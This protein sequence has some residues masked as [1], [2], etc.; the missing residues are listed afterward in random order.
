[1]TF[2]PRS[3]V[4]VGDHLRSLG[5]LDAG[6]TVRMTRAGVIVDSAPET[7]DR[8]VL[9]GLLRLFGPPAVEHRSTLGAD[10]SDLLVTAGLADA[11]GDQLRARC[12]LAIWDGLVIAHDPDSPEDVQP[13]TVLGVNNTTRTLARLT[14]RAPIGRALDVGCGG[15]ALAL[16]LARHSRSVVATDLSERAVAY[17]DLNAA[18]NGLTVDGRQGDLY[19]PARDGA[20]YDLVTANLPFVVSPETSYTFR[21]GGRGADGISQDAVAG[22]ASL[23][24]P[25]GLA[26]LLVNWIVGEGMGP[27]DRVAGW[28]EG[29]EVSAIVIHHSTEEP[30]AYARRWNEFLLTSDVAAYRATVDRWISAFERWEV[31]GIASGAVIVRRDRTSGGWR[32]WFAM[33][34]IPDAD[35]SR[36]LRRMVDNLDWST[37]HPSHADLLAQRLRLVSRHRLEQAMTYDG[38][39]QVA[40]AR[41]V[42]DDTLGVTGVVHPLAMHALMRLDGTETLGRILD[43]TTEETGLDPGELRSATLETCRA[44]VDAGCLER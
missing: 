32:R 35:A 26:I 19:D 6:A 38:T 14:P 25:G 1:M 40:P 23:L 43:R 15:G 36:Q 13:D 44:L 42:L 29:E 28:L 2:D 16:L 11:D 18:L 12:R 8:R 37:A 34:S 10:L 17:T 33:T 20:P 24:P 39:W 3:A 30:A 27:M 22:A 5:F 9:H 4:A 21:D 41:M 31:S 7:A